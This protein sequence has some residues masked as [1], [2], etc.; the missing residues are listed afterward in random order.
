MLSDK[1]VNDLLVLENKSLKAELS[2]FKLAV[3]YL[4]IDA[5]ADNK[6]IEQLRNKRDNYSYNLELCK[7]E[8]SDSEIKRHKLN[9]E[10]SRVN[11]LRQGENSNE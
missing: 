7:I 11:M 10:L 9:I 1:H 8:L 5:K 2:K 3:Q 6:E 4:R